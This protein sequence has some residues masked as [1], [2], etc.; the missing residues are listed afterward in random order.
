[1]RRRGDGV[2][3]TPSDALDALRV[4]DVVDLGAVADLDDHRATRDLVGAHPL[5]VAARSASGVESANVV[6]ALWSRS[7]AA[8]HRRREAARIPF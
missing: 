5:V 8:D 1:M 7:V 3:E 4:L 2:A 6:G